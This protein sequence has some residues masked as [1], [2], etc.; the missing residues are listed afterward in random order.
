MMEGKS[1]LTESW[2]LPVL[3]EVNGIIFK[4]NFEYNL[5]QTSFNFTLFLASGDFHREEHLIRKDVGKRP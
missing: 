5:A 3:N 4:I 1:L 2:C